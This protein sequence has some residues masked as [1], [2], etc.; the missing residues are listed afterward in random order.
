V[1]I[2]AALDDQTPSVGKPPAHFPIY[3]TAYGATDGNAAQKVPAFCCMFW[4]F[5]IGNVEISLAS[6]FSV[7]TLLM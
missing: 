2:M 5:S 7:R 3:A 1:A 6:V 4:R